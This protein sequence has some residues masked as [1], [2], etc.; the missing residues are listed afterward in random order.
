MTPFI[1]AKHAGNQLRKFIGLTHDNED[2]N[3][4]SKYTF[5]ELPGK[6]EYRSEDEDYFNVL[7]LAPRVPIKLTTRAFVVVNP[8]LAKFT[9]FNCQ[10]L[11]EVGDT[12]KI[13]IHNYTGGFT[14]MNLDWLFRIYFIK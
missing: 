12:P 13:Y 14:D 10:T 5:I 1:F 7:I 11:Y 3:Y 2:T 8:E 6:V 4:D 9:N